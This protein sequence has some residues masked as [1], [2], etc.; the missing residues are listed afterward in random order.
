MAIEQITGTDL[1]NISYYTGSVVVW[2]AGLMLVPMVTAVASAEWP[3]LVD[4][5]IGALLTL[6]VGLAF[7]L[8]GKPSKR[9]VTW[10]QGYTVAAF[11]WIV[12]MCLTAVPY[13]LSGYW[14]SYLDAAFDVMSGLTT[15]GLVLVQNLDHIPNAINMWRH[16]LTYVGGQGMV[17]LALTLLAKGL[18]GA[19]K[20]YLGEAKDERLMPSVGH[21]A[22]AIWFISLVY[23]AVGTVAQWIAGMAIG[24][25]PV[26]ALLHG[27]WV[28]MGAWSTGGFAPQAL[29]INYYH[30]ILYEVVTIPFM[31]IGSFNF[32]IH[33]A[34]FT[35]RRDEILK[36]IEIKVMVVVLTLT[37]VTALLSAA[38][39][40]IYRD[41][42]SLGRRVVY[43]MISGQT[44]TGF[45]NIWAQ[46]FYY[47]WPTLAL[48]ALI[49]SMLFGG[50]ASSTAGGF[51][52][53][54]VGIIAKSIRQEINKLMA[55]ESAIVVE[56]YHM[57]QDIPLEDKTAKISALIIL[58]YILMFG[59]GTFA[60]VA[61]GY[62][63]TMS[64]FE[65]A[66]ATGNVGLSSGLLSP[67]MPAPLKILFIFIMWAGRLEFM[68]VMVLFVV[69]WKLIRRK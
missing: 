13:Y 39:A 7:V 21:T 47:Q 25:P 46:Q 26:Q 10:T 69:A 29:N 52:G 56:K 42:L 8:A 66:S 6:C 49:L 40:G 54:R 67:L 20:L 35:G 27:L 5:I 22:R 62:P 48:L 14:A 58:L 37:T 17:V 59:A 12:V 9:G 31:I 30:S 1:K 32:G 41:V 36:N 33:N 18:P 2:L 63:L 16:L 34:A 51:K 28:F 57:H 65:A 43:Q 4:F 61:Y 38:K 44:T 55:P 50:S 68:S 64:M 15:T 3:S 11:S 60:A 45:S 23:L 19:A 24:M 53:I